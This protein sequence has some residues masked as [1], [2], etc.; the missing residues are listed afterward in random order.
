MYPRGVRGVGGIFSWTVDR[1]PWT[2]DRGPWI[3]DRG[4]H[5]GPLCAGR[6]NLN[7]K[8]G[9][10]NREQGSG[11]REQG[12]GI[13]EQGT[14]IREQGT[15]N[16][17][18]GT[19]IRDQRSVVSGQFV[20]AAKREADRL[21]E[22]QRPPFGDD[23]HRLDAAQIGCIARSE[24]RRSRA[25]VRHIEGGWRDLYNEGD[26]KSRRFHIS[27]LIGPWLSS[28]REHRAHNSASQLYYCLSFRTKVVRLELKKYRPLLEIL[29]VLLFR[30]PLT[31]GGGWTPHQR[32]SE[33]ASQRVS[34]LA[35]WRGGAE[36]R[37]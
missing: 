32:V 11:N 19:G 13:R 33:S 16:R 17:D 36:G 30:P 4:P 35:G 14:G 22:M 37:D 15:G 23:L 2:V 8:Q 29:E 20:S 26:N 6:G 21:R 34:K 7:A 28:T 31:T 12:T 1:G 27:S 9:T 25:I 10:G 5:M 18:Q 3:V 24:W